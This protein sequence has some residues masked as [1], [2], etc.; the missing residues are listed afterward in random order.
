MTDLCPI[1]GREYGSS[2]DKHHLI[3]KTRGGK[4]TTRLHKICH[5]KIHA[6]FTEKEL[7]KKFNSPEALLEN[8]EIK[9]FV[10]WVQK[11]PIDY[12]D[13]SVETRVRKGKRRS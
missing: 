6:T 1:C 3:P 11:K 4:E 13:S 7:E 10:Q 2:T 5:R 12:Y 8:E 9:K